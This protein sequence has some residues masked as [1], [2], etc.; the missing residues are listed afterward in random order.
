MSPL[1]VALASQALCHWSSRLPIGF[2]IE[3][4]ECFGN[5]NELPFPLPLLYFY[6]LLA[7]SSDRGTTVP[8]WSLHTVVA[9]ARSEQCNA[10]VQGTSH[11]MECVPRPPSRLPALVLYTMNR[12]VQ[13]EFTVSTIQIWSIGVSAKDPRQDGAPERKRD[14]RDSNSKTPTKHQNLRPHDFSQSK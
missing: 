6:Y 9:R 5:T 3:S 7:R 12:C 8:P 4:W 13:I 11:G 14:A 1:L 10:L 2:K